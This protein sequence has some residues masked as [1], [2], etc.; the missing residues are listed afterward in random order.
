MRRTRQGRRRE[1]TQ[2][3]VRGLLGCRLRLQL[4]SDI[5]EQGVEK[6][7]VTTAAVAHFQAACDEGSPLKRLSIIN[8]NNK[9]IK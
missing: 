8:N 3:D 7:I 5:V 9:I 1:V 4:R 6:R 2:A